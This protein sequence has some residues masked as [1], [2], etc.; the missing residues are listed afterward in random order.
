[1]N[2]C[3]FVTTANEAR[4]V[5][6]QR[7]VTV[8]VG[9]VTNMKIFSKV[10]S[11]I[12]KILFRPLQQPRPFQEIVRF[13]YVDHNVRLVALTVIVLKWTLVRAMTDMLHLSEASTYVSRS[14]FHRVKMDNALGQTNVCAMKVMRPQWIRVIHSASRPV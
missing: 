10:Q 4:I 8:L 9:K 13:A 14:V 1:M 7:P 5:R 12:C 11:G 3:L 6:Q 2:V